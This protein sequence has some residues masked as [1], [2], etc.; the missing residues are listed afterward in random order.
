M[1]SSSASPLVGL[2]AAAGALIII[3]STSL[4]VLQK[5]KSKKQHENGVQFCVPKSLQEEDYTPAQPTLPKTAMKK[6]ELFTEPGSGRFALELILGPNQKYPSHLHGSAE[7][8]FLVKGEIKDQFGVKQAGDFFYNEP[9]SLHFN[10]QAGEE[11][12]TILVVKDKGGNAPRPELDHQDCC[13]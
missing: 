7:W 1:A 6:R 12:C 9:F 2:S 3:A 10:I 4:L 5:N 8:C 11:G 13:C